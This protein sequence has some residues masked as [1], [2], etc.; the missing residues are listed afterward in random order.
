MLSFESACARL[1]RA[2]ARARVCAC[3][4]VCMHVC[5]SMCVC[6]CGCAC[7]CACVCVC[8]T[9]RVSSPTVFEEA[10]GGRVVVGMMVLEGTTSVMSDI[11]INVYKE[12]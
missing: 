10:L 9:H 1:L 3:L 2:C 11:C 6:V 4:C 12:V 5:V 7:A 8:V